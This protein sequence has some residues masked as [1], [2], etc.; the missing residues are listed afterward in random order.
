M[1]PS[2]KKGK[3]YGKLQPAGLEG[4]FANATFSVFIL[5]S[6]TFMVY[7]RSLSL[8]YTKLDDSI[9]IVENAQYNADLKNIS[10]SFQRGLF[11][12]TKDAYYRPL[13]LVDFILESRLFGIKPAGYHFTNLLF[14]IISV[15]LLFLFLKR[16][17]IPPA[18]S[19]LLSLLFAVH[20]C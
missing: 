17:K 6:V 19:F 9:F 3:G 5:A 2:K 20:R 14:H 1:K 11:N 10:V 8:D 16:I 4:W 13:F 15:I 12:P 7:A 18:D